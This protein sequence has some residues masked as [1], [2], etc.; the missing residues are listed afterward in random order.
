[1]PRKTRQYLVI[2]AN[3]RVGRE[4]CRQLG[5]DVIAKTRESLDITD[6]EN[7][8]RTLMLL[9][10]DAVINAAAYTDWLSAEKNQERC[11]K[12]NTFAVHNLA[13]CCGDLELPLM[14]VSDARVFG[15]EEGRKTPYS[16]EDCVGP[17]NF[18]AQSKAAAEQAILRTAFNTGLKHWI[19]RTSFV[20]ERPWRESQDMLY[21]ILAANRY[22]TP[23]ETLSDVY[24]SPT[25]APHLAKALIHMLDNRNEI[26]SG[27][28][29]V[30]NKGSVSI[31][32]LG[33][34]LIRY[35]GKAMA[36]APTST[37]AMCQK[38]G[39]PSSMW[40]RFTP[41]DTSKFERECEYSLPT[42]QEGLQGYIDAWE[43]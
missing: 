41:L 40:P 14:H 24:C 8:R 27:T 16:E 42:W 26:E 15:Q 4:I 28:Y 2:G 35:S 21:K 11:W 9:K 31:H 18:Y 37:E 29:H 32:Q 13:N 1:M 25:Y 19:I 22:R 30:A 5:D 7:T 33:L 43:D 38:N 6:F 39:I 10:P 36:L 20:Y 17:V 23:V 3:S 12:V 34:E